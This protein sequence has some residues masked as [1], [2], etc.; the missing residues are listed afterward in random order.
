M[1]NNLDTIQTE[2]LSFYG[3]NEAD[4]D[5]IVKWRS[6]PEVYKYFKSSHK[7]TRE[8]HLAWYRSSYL[9]NQNRF[10]WICIEKASSKKIGVFGLV[11]EDDLAEV[12]Y[13]L[14]PEAQH[15]GYA[16]EGIMALVRYSASKWN[17]KMVYAEIH[18]KNLPSIKAVKKLDF[19]IV[20]NKGDFVKY[21]IEV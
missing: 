9:A 3:I 5:V 13:L 10:D 15:K 14:D 17:I 1:A 12:N 6:N 8:E 19:H 11:R 18:K 7:I 4:V 16:L 21:G 2:R 20:E